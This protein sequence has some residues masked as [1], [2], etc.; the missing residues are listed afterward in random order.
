MARRHGSLVKFTYRG[1]AQYWTWPA[2]QDLVEWWCGTRVIGWLF[3]RGLLRWEPT[4]PLKKDRYTRVVPVGGD[5]AF[6][7]SNV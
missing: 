5:G 3:Q 7:V 6:V 1:S 4:S 2:E